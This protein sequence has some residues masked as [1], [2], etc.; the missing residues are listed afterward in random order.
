MPK[1]LLRTTDH[2]QRVERAQQFRRPLTAMEARL[3]HHVRDRKCAGVKIRRQVVVGAFIVDFLCEA[4]KVIIEIDGASHDGQIDYDV[5]R[6]EW[7]QTQGYRVVRFTNDA[8]RDQLEGVLIR[9]AEHCT[10]P[11]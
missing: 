8:V 7:L 11:P 3:W 1:R 9:I 5:A 10:Q 4:A 2:C 6:T